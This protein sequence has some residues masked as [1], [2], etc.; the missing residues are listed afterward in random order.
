VGSSKFIFGVQCDEEQG[1][2]GQLQPIV[3]AVALE[4]VREAEELVGVALTLTIMLVSSPVNRRVVALLGFPFAVGA[5]IYLC[6]L[7]SPSL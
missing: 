5:V 6:S 4:G 1:G 3:P 2:C 7:I